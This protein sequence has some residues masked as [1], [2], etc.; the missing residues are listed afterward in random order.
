MNIQIRINAEKRITKA[1][2]KSILDLG[3]TVDVDNGEERLTNL[4]A[5][6]ALEHALS[7]DECNVY[8]RKPSVTNQGKFVTVAAFFLVYGNDGYDC[9]CDHS[10]N[11]ETDQ[12]LLAVNPLVEQ[13]EERLA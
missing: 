1:L 13:L 5:K 3:Y 2:I 6:A 12:I 10:V 8:A 7:V 11:E 4:T 9:I